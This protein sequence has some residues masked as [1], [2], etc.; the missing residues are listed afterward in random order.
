M[1]LE[2]LR[3]EYLRLTRCPTIEDSYDLLN[4][5]A[6]YFLQTIKNHQTEPVKT[7]ALRDAKMVN[8]MMLTKVLH[9]RQ[10]VDGV[11]FTSTD[12]TIL[13][14][15]I[16]PTIVA[17]LIRNVYE[18][19]SMFNLVYR[20]TK[21]EDEKLI[22]YNLWAIAG[23]NYRQKFESLIATAE[24]EQKLKDEKQH[25]DNLVSE[26]E[27]TKLYIGLDQ[28]DK[29]KIHIKIKE[30]D[31]KIR[32][33]N[34]KVIFLHWQELCDTMGVKFGLFEKIYT[35]FSLYS[36]PS[37]VAVFQFGEM[38]YNE[39]KAF[40]DLTNFNLKNL[41]ALLSIFIADF[42]HLFPNVLKTFENQ[43]LINQIV[44]NGYNKLFRDY[45]YSINDTWKQ[46]G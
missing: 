9:I 16:D 18:T 46:L 39:D 2:Q 37:N 29:E 26:I 17:A 24:N 3:L 35:Y 14:A 32:F 8:Q 21:T 7:V 38:F 4:I 40:L 19:A 31:F 41:F 22:L 20:H 12:G 42:I 13:N 5:Y 33:E 36:H 34:N 15:I 44:V 6:D 23:L 11:G 1:E 45:D 43:T 25:I 30:K 27:N 28:K 10:V